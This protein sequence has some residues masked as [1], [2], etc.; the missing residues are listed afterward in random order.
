MTLDNMKPE[1]G[2]WNSRHTHTDTCG[3]VDLMVKPYSPIFSGL[4][5]PIPLREESGQGNYVTAG[6]PGHWLCELTKPD[7]SQRGRVHH[8]M[9]LLL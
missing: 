8:N 1:R 7:P 4:T 9:H 3:V 2:M 6:Q 5:V